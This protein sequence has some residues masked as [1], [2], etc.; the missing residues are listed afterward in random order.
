[1]KK[2]HLA[3]LESSLSRREKKEEEESEI[4]VTKIL[5]YS[6]LESI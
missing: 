4:S 6:H 5:E 2:S 1:M 3:K